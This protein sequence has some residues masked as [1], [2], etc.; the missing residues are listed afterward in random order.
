MDV[1]TRQWQAADGEAWSRGGSFWAVRELGIISKKKLQYSL[2]EWGTVA[3]S[4]VTLL[5]PL[6]MHCDLLGSSPLLRVLIYKM[7]S[8]QISGPNSFLA[9]KCF[10]QIKITG[11]TLTS[12]KLSISGEGRASGT[13]RLGSTVYLTALLPAVANGASGT[14]GRDDILGCMH[15]WMFHPPKPL[16]LPS[17]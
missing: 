16:A 5:L 1:S 2:K 8:D 14:R 6:F 3:T 11:G 7:K 4:Q 12:K 9:V 17:F 15:L 13:C 10:V